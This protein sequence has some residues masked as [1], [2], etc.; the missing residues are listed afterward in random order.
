MSFKLV[1]ALGEGT[2][3][4]DGRSF[5]S[6]C[7]VEDDDGMRV[8]VVPERS[9]LV[10]VWTEAHTAGA[11]ALAVA[12]PQGFAWCFT[13]DFLADR[14]EHRSGTLLEAPEGI[15]TPSPMLP[16]YREMHEHLRAAGEVPVT[17]FVHLHAH[18]EFSPL[19]GLS[20]L[21][22]MVAAAVADGQPAMALTDH[23]ICAGHP[24]LQASCNKAGIKPIF[25]IEAYFVDDR[26][27]RGDPTIEGD[28][29]EAMGAYYHLILWA[30]DDE[31][32]RN[33]WAAST[34]AN[35]EGFYV[36]PRMDWD[37]LE[38]LNK[39][40]MCSTGCLRGPVARPLL[41]GNVELAISNMS[42]L[43]AIFGDRLYVEVQTNGL[44]EQV[45]VNHALV[46]F[47]KVYELPVIAACDSHYPT[48]DD[49][50]THRA[51]IASQTNKDVQDEGE[52]FAASAARYHMMTAAEVREQLA[53]LGE[54]VVE[55]AMLNTAI[56]ASRCNAKLEGST[57]NPI[58]SKVGGIERDVE[59]MT[60]LCL[61]N[62]QRKCVGKEAPEEEYTARFE[63]EMKLFVEKKFAGYML[64]VA[65][66]CKAAKRMG[67][68]VGPGRGSGGGSLVADLLDITEIDPIEGD[69]LFE[70]FLN[71]GRK[72]PPDF[73]VDFP[74][75]RA[76]DLL[77][78]IVNK[79]GEANVVRVG[80][81]IRLKNKGVVRA[82]FSALRKD[83]E[84]AGT[85]LHWPDLTLISAI[86]TAAEADKAGKGMPWEDLWDEH[87]EMLQPFRDKYP[88]LFDY[89]D[90]MV[91][92]LK[93][94]GKHAAGFII[95]TDEPLTGRL[96]L[97]MGENGQ[98]VAE[99]DMDSLAALG[100]IKFDLLNLRNLDTI[101]LCVDQVR[102]RYGI[103]INPY[104]WV[105]E[106]RDPQVWAEVSAG[107]TLGIFQIETRAGTKI[108]RRMEPASVRD[109]A[110][111]IT[112]VRPGPMRSGLTDTY[113]RRKAG[114][115]EMLVADPRLEPVLAKTYGTILYQED[116][117]AV[118]MIV[119]GYTAIEAD[120]ARKIMG[121]KQ[122]DKV[123]AEGRR[124]VA[125]AV[126][127]GAERGV[128]ERLW[129][130]LAEFAKYGFNR[131][132]AWGYAVLGYWTAW[133]KF[134]YP[135]QFLTSALST[136]D[137]DRI[138][139]FINEARRM[140]YK[141]L[142][143]DIN[144][145]GVGF[146]AA[147][148]TVRYGLDS[149]K[150]VG[151]KAVGAI[152]QG[153]PYS[154][155]EDFLARKGSAANSGVV[156]TLAAVGAFDTMESNRKALERRLEW[157]TSPESTRCTMRDDNVLGP[158]GLPCTFDWSSEPV[159][160]GKSGKALKARPIP[161][162]C[163]RACRHYDAPTRVETIHPYTD[164]EIREREKEWLGVYLSSTPF[165]YIPDEAV[166]ECALG[167]EVEM[168]EPGD[169]LVVCLLQRTRPY[170]AKN[171]SHMGFISIDARGA[172][173][174]VTVLSDSWE[175]YRNDLRVGSLYL[176][177][178]VKNMRGLKMTCLWP[179]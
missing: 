10:R 55:T 113:F 16:S 61:E 44:P 90:R 132:H 63:R 29:K 128:A 140:G 107:H 157:E 147:G 111:A 74:T 166:E 38:R 46:E 75:S 152:L 163:T 125:N 56:V 173:L 12:G 45:T 6:P 73:D 49:H 84:D 54:D 102:E 11:V 179:L 106:Y 148:M 112:L 101:Q 58:Y 130:Q 127:R 78:Y 158:N 82:L 76:E 91:G 81:Q 176:M 40:I 14:L 145:S 174:D 121:K 57:E 5:P 139:E 64:I 60:E 4:I 95:S 50:D 93:T 17:Q 109:L 41:Q 2:V 177:K 117:M 133:L 97:R 23:G 79:Y 169:Y 142:P 28:A 9:F 149:V 20:M 114:E 7:L 141:V 150:G 52:L 51:W 27:R 167:S 100:F 71:E 124:F 171:G 3:V 123:E 1:Q 119:A 134:H 68:L 108:T 175:K 115:E 80:S 87:G 22:E 88:K 94:Y 92:R 62:W 160:L 98:L 135:V 43:K 165:D 24:V 69:L 48:L 67:I 13:E 172:D 104:D 77:A 37:T 70:R 156:K 15:L 116:V 25:G 99:F 47:A 137:K 110:D 19:D 170:T 153:Q 103:V 35:R 33:L 161:K 105:E 122:T 136:V 154:D 26:F 53:Y 72:E 120:A 178:L 118:C 162:K 8:L 42:R 138:P 36:H 146:K 31:G 34:E 85:P 168:G 131:A 30:M 83:M 126:E 89:A 129:A 96:P 143:P 39:G 151:E 18:S 66:Y 32:L 164:V 86:I 144:E 155:F 59:R 21:D 159:V 65:D